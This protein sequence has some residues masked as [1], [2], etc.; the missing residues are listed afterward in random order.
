MTSEDICSTADPLSLSDDQTTAI[1]SAV[2]KA[3]GP[4]LNG[5][6]ISVSTTR[7]NRVNNCHNLYQWYMNDFKKSPLDYCTLRWDGTLVRD[8]LGETYP[9]KGLA[10]LVFGTLDYEEGKLLGVPLIKSSTGIQQCNATLELIETWGLTDNTIFLVF[11]NT[12][13]NSGSNKGQ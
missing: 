4:D 2:L 1:A 10:V 5:F 9:V 7:R 12:E 11:D 13:S 3:G 8:V 6:I